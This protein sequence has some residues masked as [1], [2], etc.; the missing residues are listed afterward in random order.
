[1][2]FYELIASRFSVREY[3]DEPV[4]EDTV[5]H[6]VEA[7]RLAPSACNNQP[8]HF[9]VVRDPEMRRQLFERQ[10]WAVTAPVAIVVCSIP[11]TAWVRKFDEKNHADVDLGIAMEHIVLAATEE[12]LGSCW[13]CAFDPARAREILRLPAGMEPVAMTPIGSNAAAMRPKQRKSL[14]DLV[15]WL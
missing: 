1:M 5:L 3:L 13:I 8:W 2:N 12:G 4:A 10:P 15:T 7:A 11:E 14:D 6:I 9:Y